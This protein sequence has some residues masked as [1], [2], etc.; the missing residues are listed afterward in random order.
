MTMIEIQD[1]YIE[2]VSVA[3]GKITA[4]TQGHRFARCRAAA[5]REAIRQLAKLGY[6]EEAA[7]QI[8]RDAH[9][10]FILEMAASAHYDEGL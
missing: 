8:V 4:R 6:A 2:R 9:D 7:K 5:R 3:H 10:I 1:A